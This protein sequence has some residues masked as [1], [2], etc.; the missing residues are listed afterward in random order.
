MN[1]VETHGLTK[2]YG[3]WRVVD[4]LNMHV[5]QG[6]IYG[7][8]GRNGAGKSTVMRMICGLASPTEG[9][10][11]LFGQERAS[12]QQR[13][14]ALIEAPGILPN[15]TAYGNLMAKALALGIADA[16]RQCDRVISLVGLEGAENKKAKG[17]SL[18]MRQR[19]GVALALIGS[20]DLLVL[21]EPLNG[22]DP[23]GTRDMRN[24]LVSL[25]QTQGTT[26]LISSHVLDQLD[27]MATRY[28]VIA[29]GRLVR[30]MT[31]EQV[32]AECEDSLR[33]RTTDPARTLAIL[34]SALPSVA[35][36]AEPDGAI[37]ATRYEDAAAISQVLSDARQTVLELTVTQRDLEEYFLNL[38]DEGA[39]HV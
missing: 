27:R 14:G 12:A 17:Y 18:G 33:I 34:Q 24:L 31:A 29:S 28:G 38:M 20:P 39:R 26:I 8:V 37:I 5:R 13:V 30:E 19:L 21:D 9:S 3:R 36:R 10:V 11:T 4:N 16:P 2:T 32:Q 22:L 7:F 6:D 25:N 23:R 15:L 35:F 1:V